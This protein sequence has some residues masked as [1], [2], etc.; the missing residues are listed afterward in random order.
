MVKS[1]GECYPKA[2]TFPFWDRN[3]KKINITGK[4][5]AE[6]QE[7][8]GGPEGILDLNYCLPAFSDA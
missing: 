1:T 3:V 2:G 8:K 6:P 4:V 5:P 7:Q